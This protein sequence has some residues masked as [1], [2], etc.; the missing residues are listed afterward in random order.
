[1]INRGVF[2][3]FV[4]TIIYFVYKRVGVDKNIHNLVFCMPLS[5]GSETTLVL[6]ESLNILWI[7]WIVF[8]LYQIGIR[9]DQFIV[10]LINDH[11]CLINKKKKYIIIWEINF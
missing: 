3:L 7:G 5:T 6:F 11:P 9:I 4:I 1:M 8:I 2:N 10:I